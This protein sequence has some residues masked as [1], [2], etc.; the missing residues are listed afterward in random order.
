MGALWAEGAHPR[1]SYRRAPRI[2]CACV[3]LAAASICRVTA[4]EADDTA[5][6]AIFAVP[7]AKPDRPRLRAAA[8]TTR[9]DDRRHCAGGTAHS[10]ASF[11]DFA[12]R[13]QAKIRRRVAGG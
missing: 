5:Y 9:S 13:M 11:I 7:R 8:S 10:P 2:L 4:H 6:V 12:T 1:H 3:T